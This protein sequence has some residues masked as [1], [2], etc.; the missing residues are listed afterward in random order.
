MPH[1]FVCI[2]ARYDF[3]ADLVET[4]MNWKICSQFIDRIN[5]IA[6]M[7][8][9]APFCSLP[10]DGARNLQKRRS[11]DV[12]G[13]STDVVAPKPKHVNAPSHKTLRN[14]V[15]H[16]SSSPVKRSEA[17][18]LNSRPTPESMGLNIATIA[19]T[20]VPRKSPLS[21]IL[22]DESLVDFVCFED[23]GEVL[24]YDQ[25]PPASVSFGDD[26]SDVGTETDSTARLS[27]PGTIYGTKDV[28]VAS[29]RSA[30]EA[31]SPEEGKLCIATVSDYMG[32]AHRFCPVTKQ[33]AWLF[34]YWQSE[35]ARNLF[36]TFESEKAREGIVRHIE[37]LE[38]INEHTWA[39]YCRDCS[40]TMREES[41]YELI[42]IKATC[43]LKALYIAHND[44]RN[45]GNFNQGCEES[46][47]YMVEEDIDSVYDAATVGR[48]FA[49]FRTDHKFTIA[50]SSFVSIPIWE[51][52]SVSKLFAA[53][54]GESAEEALNRHIGSLENFSFSNWTDYCEKG[55]VKYLK[56]AAQAIVT[57]K[58]AY[59]LAVLCVAKYELQH[60][61]SFRRCCHEVA[62]HKSGVDGL[63]TVD[64][65]AVVYRWFTEF[66][67]EHKFEA[68]VFPIPFWESKGA[69]LLFGATQGED[70]KQKV[71]GYIAKLQTFETDWRDLMVKGYSVPFSNHEKAALCSKVVYVV[72]AFAIAL[73]Y[74]PRLD[75]I[76]CCEQAV[77]NI[78]PMKGFTKVANADIVEEYAW[79]FLDNGGKF[80]S[81]TQPIET[82][83]VSTGEWF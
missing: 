82:E 17:K 66:R 11:N 47:L 65:A 69:C 22:S 44:L 78:A 24:I 55:K 21:E 16:G 20:S 53:Q 29:S 38:N 62:V 12:L 9:R 10:N 19:E 79:E 76:D 7:K 26:R 3:E 63:S 83:P 49:D 80:N 75:W 13:K 15:V 40:S 59:V 46:I 67:E 41:I 52:S 8:V 51:R 72:H 73:R 43:V 48:W 32:H 35:E 36:T 70:I 58:V 50:D 74:M 60:Y 45:C 39:E 64:D 37:A 14:H 42:N 77:K 30:A 6:I 33:P 2:T 23:D 68:P 28:D 57:T 18:R 56:P 1:T 4:G 27:T 61:K 34:D 71:A 25:V 81:V 54:P 5:C 31:A